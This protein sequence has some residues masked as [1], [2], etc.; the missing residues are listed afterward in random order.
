[1]ASTEL[2]LVDRAVQRSLPIVPAPIEGDLSR[3]AAGQRRLVMGQD[4]VYI[5]AASHVLHTIKPIGEC[6]T[7]FGQ[8]PTGTTPCFG[9]LGMSL[10][11][12]LIKLAR[13]AGKEE[14]A[15]LIVADDENGYVIVRP[16]IISATAGEVTYDESGIDRSRLV[17]DMHSHGRFDSFF[18][19]QD[20][21]S[22]LSRM[23]P[24]VSLVVGRCNTDKPQVNA[25]LVIPPYLIDVSLDEVFE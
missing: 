11:N 18:S 24:H 7:P 21:A 3:V 15:A 6:T 17:V 14:T 13:S 8:V 16:R 5:E 9:K 23:G 1:M 20:D 25:R 2:S 12:E 22:D 4:G 10:L 19:A